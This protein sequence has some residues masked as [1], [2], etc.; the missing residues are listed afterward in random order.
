MQTETI[1][2]LPKP[3]DNI[4]A[5]LGDIS[6][7]PPMSAI[8]DEFKRHG[9]NPWVELAS[10]W[11]FS[12]LKQAP[13]FKEGIDGKAAMRALSACLRSF[14]PKHEHKTAGV[15]YLLSL[16]CEPDAVKIKGDK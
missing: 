13:R 3:V 9:G 4:A 6:N 5:A 14:E 11:F 12:G 1:P 16:W 15:A 10:R 2:F 7:L 8:P